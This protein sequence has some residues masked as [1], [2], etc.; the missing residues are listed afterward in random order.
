MKGNVKQIK[1]SEW[2]VGNQ[3]Y[4]HSHD[5]H[6]IRKTC[7]YAET[8]EGYKVIIPESEVLTY[9]GRKRFSDNLIEE[10]NKALH[11][12]HIGFEANEDGDYIL[13][14]SLSSYL[15]AIIKD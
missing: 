11:N 15:D 2:Y 4:Q 13:S 14:M 6:D 1:R 10:L 8:Y 7:L 3:A 9:Y 5:F 12:K